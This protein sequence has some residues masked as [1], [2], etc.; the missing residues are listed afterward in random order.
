MYIQQYLDEMKIVQRVLLEFIENEVNNEETF[1]N[2]EKIFTD[3]KICDDKYKIKSIL[4]L[5]TKISDEHHHEPNFYSKIERIFIYFKKQIEKYFTNWE[6]FNIC[7][8]NKR[9]MLFLI[10]E[11]LLNIDDRIY[12]VIATQDIYR[13]NKYPEYF[14]PEIKAFKKTNFA[15]KNEKMNE[16][17]TNELPEDFYNN[18]KIGE[19]ESFICKL[20]REDLVTEFITYYNRT[21]FSLETNIQQ[22]IYE[23]N[24]FLTNEEKVSLI[25]YAAFCGSIQIFNYLKLNEIKLNSSLLLFSIHGKNAEIIQILEE[26]NIE[27]ISSN[28]YERRFLESIKCHHNDIAEYFL[29]NISNV[30]DLDNSKKITIILKHYNFAYIENSMINQ[31]SFIYLCGYD[32]YIIVDNILKKQDIELNKIDILKTFFYDDLISNEL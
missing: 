7:K 18:R 29:N 2:V 8:S 15:Q 10:E 22:S 6:I 23:T 16:E 25:E 17:T 4:Y 14:S 30:K 28:L 26:N 21:N 12:E 11:Q 13:K 1:G 32:Y 31:S 3:L 5:T 19:N 20:I 9:I 24:S 27:E